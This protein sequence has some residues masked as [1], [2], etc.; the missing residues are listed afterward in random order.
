LHNFGVARTVFQMVALSNSL[1]L[2][3]LLEVQLRSLDLALLGSVLYEL[4]KV[5]LDWTTLECMFQ[6]ALHRTNVHNIIYNN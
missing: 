2:G 6:V 1:A 3:I 5:L 4:G